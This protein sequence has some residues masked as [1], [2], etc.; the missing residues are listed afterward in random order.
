[1]KRFVLS[2]LIGV[3]VGA[4]SAVAGAQGVNSNPNTGSSNTSNPTAGN[5]DQH[6]DAI[7]QCA[8]KTGQARDACMDQARARS[9]GAAQASQPGNRAMQ[10]MTK[11]EETMSMP[12]P[13]QANDHSTV[14]KDRDSTPD[15]STSPDRGPQTKTQS[16]D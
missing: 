1:M 4:V 16:S 7:K 8:T 14:A 11:E 12:L 15:E 10:S 9:Q 6:S 13:G 5:A 3:A 2:L